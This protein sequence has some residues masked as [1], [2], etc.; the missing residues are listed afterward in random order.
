MS[1]L[2]HLEHVQSTAE[3]IHPRREVEAA[4]SR[5]AREITSQ[6]SGDNPVVL[7]LLNGGII[8]C[9]KLLVELPFPLQLDSVSIG[10]Y[11]G[12]TRGS[13]I[14]WRL[15]PTVPLKGRTVLLV[16][17]VL[18]EGITLAEVKRFCLEEGA[19]RVL[20]A[21]LVDKKLA[22]EKPCRADYVGLE[23][24]DRYLFGYGM[25]YKEY[26]RNAA[27]IFACTRF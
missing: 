13:A 19:A 11:G 1:F 2:E 26:L 16:D 17:D 7:T 25:D 5:V 24:D 21:V 22:R 18:D 8:F 14:R 15:K 9:G 23:A 10:R 27:G 20:I 4:I 12:E 3:P 6:I